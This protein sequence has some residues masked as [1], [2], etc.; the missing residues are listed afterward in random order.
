[1]KFHNA[2]EEILASKVKIAVMKL[3]CL[4]PEKR[5]TGREMARLLKI[6]ASRVS[7]VLELFRK[8]AVVKRERVGKA[9]QWGL[10]KE[11]ALVNEV[12]SLINLEGKIYRELKSR[13]YET[14]IKEK[15][16]IKVV[17]YGS[18]ARKKEKPESNIDVFILV[19]TKK[20]KELAADLVGKLNKYLLPRYGNVISEVIYSEREWKDM[21]RTKIF[22]KIESEG[23]II[24][25]REEIRDEKDVR[26]FD[27][28]RSEIDWDKVA[29][30]YGI[31]E[32][33]KNIKF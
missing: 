12:S 28:D 24:L 21:G 1:M 31:E 13:I 29:E 7:E 8:N 30:V 22:K 15:S 16:I 11:S 5:Y 26:Y 32:L 23:E 10:N 25:I 18:V 19:R 6:S 17:L 33:I 9:L 14:L 2:L 27:K 3:M 4:N 20:D